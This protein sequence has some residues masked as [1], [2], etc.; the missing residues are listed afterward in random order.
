MIKKKRLIE[1]D[2]KKYIEK[3]AKSAALNNRSQRDH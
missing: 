2:R 1:K 3:R